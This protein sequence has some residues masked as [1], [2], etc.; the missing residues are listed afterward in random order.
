MSA[1]SDIAAGQLPTVAPA[2]PSN[3]QPPILV[4]NSP[5]CVMQPSPAPTPKSTSLSPA[6][7]VQLTA[8]YMEMDIDATSTSISTDL[9]WG[10]G[11]GIE[12]GN[13]TINKQLFKYQSNAFAVDT[14]AF[15]D[16]FTEVGTPNASAG[17][18]D[19]LNS[20]IF[21]SVPYIFGPTLFTDGGSDT[22]AFAQLKNRAWRSQVLSVG[23]NFGGTKNDYNADLCSPCFNSNDLVIMWSLKAIPVS[24][25]TPVSILIPDGLKGT[26][27]FCVMS[28]GIN[29]DFIEI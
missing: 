20:A 8:G 12:A 29:Y 13:G 23:G 19:Y 9:I 14:A 24:C 27:R 26:F 16:A 5:G 18:S 1:L 21:N 6:Q 2:Q 7:L 17:S 4:A 10:L 15:T 11:G 22:G 3:S 25:L 28:N